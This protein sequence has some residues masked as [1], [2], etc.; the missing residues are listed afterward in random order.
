M[1]IR[2]AFAQLGAIQ[3]NVQWSVSAWNNQQELVLSLW[4]DPAFLKK[5]AEKAKTYVYSDHVSRWSGLGQQEMKAN[6]QQAWQQSAPIRI[7]LSR[8]N[9]PHQI[10]LIKAGADAST[11]SKTFYAKPDWRGTLVLWDGDA[12]KIEIVQAI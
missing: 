2:D 6:L 7:V 8:L 12:F 3:K 1:G 11:F 5:H 10:E 9:Q 4:N